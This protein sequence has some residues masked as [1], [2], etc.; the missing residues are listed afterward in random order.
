VNRSLEI[1]I[2]GRKERHPAHVS[3]PNTGQRP[4][5][6][7]IRDKSKQRQERFQPLHTE[8]QVLMNMIVQATG[9]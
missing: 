1:L 6:S 5:R 8:I 7:A 9:K 2:Q 4:F 3:T